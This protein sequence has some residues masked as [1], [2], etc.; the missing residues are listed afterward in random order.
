MSELFTPTYTAPE[1]IMLELT[2][3][4]TFSE[5]DKQYFAEVE[6]LEIIE[7]AEAYIELELSRQYIIPFVGPSGE[8]FNQITVPKTIKIITKLCTLY[9]CVLLMSGAFGKREGVRGGNYIELYQKLY[10]DFLQKITDKDPQSG[11][12]RNPPLRGLA[13]NPFSSYY[14]PGVQ[15]SFVVRLGSATC[16]LNEQVRRRDIK[17]NGNWWY[18]PNRRRFC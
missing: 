2:G 17:I 3:K 1:T 7:E 4:V 6:V 5:S 12:W 10:D 18:A 9:A 13:Q 11:Q 16:S 15:P 14:Q 8:A